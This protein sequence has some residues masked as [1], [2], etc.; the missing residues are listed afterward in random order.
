[1]AQTENSFHKYLTS[2]SENSFYKF[3]R[4]SINPGYFTSLGEIY[5][6]KYAI[7]VDDK[8]LSIS[9]QLFLN[10]SI[11]FLVLYGIVKAYLTP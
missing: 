1:M 11:L 10:I 7:E 9:I 5:E 6:K 8:I 2:N 4:S 3:S